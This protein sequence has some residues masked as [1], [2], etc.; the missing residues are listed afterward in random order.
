[1]ADEVTINLDT[2][3]EIP[4]EKVV[5]ATDENPNPNE[6]E[7]PAHT[8]EDEED[9]SLRSNEHAGDEELAAAANDE[10]REAIRERR[11]EERKNRK[12]AQRDREES[13]RRELAS[14]DAIINDLRNRVDQVE[15]RNSGSELAQVENAK[16][17]VAQNYAF[18]KEQI[19]VAAEAGNGKA[20][21]EAT[22]K[23]IQA[24]R[25]FD[26]LN[27][28]EKAL[29]SRQTTPQPLDPRL[30]S[31]AQAWMARNPWYNPSSNDQDSE[32]VARLDA[33][34]AEEG[35][36]PTTPQYWQELDSR[37]KKYIP[38]RGNRDK[39]INT[40]PRSVVQGSGR[41]AS[42]QVSGASSYTLSA[43]RVHALKEAGIWDDPKQ[44]AEAVKRFQAYDK[45]NP[46][47]GN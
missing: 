7:L 33:R 25:R 40:K 1:M 14:R 15:K 32:I 39:I 42:K 35:W 38:H 47:Q 29:K 10:D 41:E 13:L 9:E 27:S 37:V 28:H 44:R 4:V 26:E 22:E 34:L 19:A 2:G 3:E 23:M 16:K 31:Q 20:V 46:N 17:Q 11:R 36:D 8:D 18:F 45:E 24:Q 5:Q 43:E 21:A 12:Q 6:N 30:V